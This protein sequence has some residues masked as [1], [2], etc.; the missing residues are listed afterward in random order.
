MNP[1]LDDVYIFQLERTIRAIKRYKK[2]KM[3]DTGLD[4]TSDQWVLIKRISEVPGINQKALAEA[5]FKDPASVTRILDLLEKKG[6]IERHAVENNRREYSLHLTTEGENLVH[7]MLPIAIDIRAQGVK[8]IAQEDMD[9][10]KE[11]LQKIH[12]NFE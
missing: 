1:K 2:V 4:V 3:K 7:K 5:S 12:N 6:L 10:L 8:G 9:K 11:I